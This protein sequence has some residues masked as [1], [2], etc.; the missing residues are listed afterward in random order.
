MRRCLASGGAATQL[1]LHVF[2]WDCHGQNLE[3][4]SR[5]LRWPWTRRRQRRVSQLYK[6]WTARRLRRLTFLLCLMYR[7]RRRFLRAHFLVERSGS[8]SMEGL[9]TVC[10]GVL[11]LIQFRLAS[12]LLVWIIG[13]VDQ[14][15][16]DCCFL[17]AMRSRRWSRIR[18]EP[19]PIGVGLPTISTNDV[20]KGL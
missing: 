19:S 10:N 9:F 8:R 6:R 13:V 16:G 5:S 11:V 1:H 18:V 14:T 2:R 17:D 15:S 7:A 20:G 3:P 4:T 12:G